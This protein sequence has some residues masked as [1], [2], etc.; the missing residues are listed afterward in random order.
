MIFNGFACI[1]LNLLYVKVK[2][3]KIV[4]CILSCFVFGFKLQT[5]GLHSGTIIFLVA[6]S[7]F[8]DIDIYSIDNNKFYYL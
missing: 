3:K 7:F 2:N 5:S 1:F 6:Q 8:S 4:F